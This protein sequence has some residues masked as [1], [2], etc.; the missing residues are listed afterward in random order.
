VSSWYQNLDGGSR[1][2]SRELPRPNGRGRPRSGRAPQG[3]SARADAGRAIGLRPEAALR[4]GARPERRPARTRLPARALVPLALLVALGAAACGYRAG[5]TLPEHT[6]TVGV[7]VFDNDS[8]LR[9]IE[10]DLAQSLARAVTDRVSAPLVPSGRA[11]VVVRGRIVD[12]RRRGG[13]RT[14]ENELLETGIRFSVE[15]SLVRRSTG[16]VLRE[17]STSLWSGYFAGDLESELAARDRAFVY[18][19]EELVLDLFRPPD[20]TEGS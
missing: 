15:A 11:D 8:L 9:N 17:T 4:R 1:F 2:G 19:A 10:L 5:L 16:E 12:Y 13:I 14:R 18:L 20:R 7:E 6:E 3:S